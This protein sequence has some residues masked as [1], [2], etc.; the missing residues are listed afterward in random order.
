MITETL[1]ERH[2]SLKKDHSG[3]DGLSHHHEQ[4]DDQPLKISISDHKE[5][6]KHEENHKPTRKI[7]IKNDDSK[8]SPNTIT[9]LNH[10]PPL[11]GNEK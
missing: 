11:C 7:D 4:K 1:A 5:E 10:K 6:K 9:P 3:E 8:L 2:E